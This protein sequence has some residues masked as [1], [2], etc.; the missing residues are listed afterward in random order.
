M[1]LESNYPR[2]EIVQVRRRLYRPVL[3]YAELCLVI[4]LALVP[5]YY[6][7]KYWFETGVDP[8]AYRG[9]NHGVYAY[10]PHQHIIGSSYAGLFCYLVLSG[11]LIKKRPK[12]DLRENFLSWPWVLLA[13]LK[14]AAFFVAFLVGATLI[15]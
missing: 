8:L 12:K 3:F 6:A 15:D 5:V 10:G 1:S 2:V 9:S 14:I 13:A 4:G 7:L 11:I